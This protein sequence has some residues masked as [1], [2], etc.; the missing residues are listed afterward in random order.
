MSYHMTS[1][2]MISHSMKH[3]SHMSKMSMTE[4]HKKDEMQ[5]MATKTMAT[6]SMKSQ[7]LKSHHNPKLTSSTALVTESDDDSPLQQDC[8]SETCNCFTGGCAS[9]VVALIK[10]DTIHYAVLDLSSK[11]FS[12]THLALSH[13]PT[14]LYR[15]PILS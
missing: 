9:A 3:M 12:F 1:H 14:S 8:C 6:K 4:M 15:P 10:N 7:S 11:I 5:P 13:Q 2:S